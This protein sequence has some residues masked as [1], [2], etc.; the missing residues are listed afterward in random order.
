VSLEGESQLIVPTE[1][2]GLVLKTIGGGDL[3]PYYALVDRNREHLNQR[4]DY[5]FEASATR[6]QLAAWLSSETADVRFGIWLDGNLIGRVYLGPVDPP[7][8]A[9]GYWLGAEST[10]QGIATVACRAAIGHGR[11]LGAS[12]IHAQI[13]KGNEASIAVVRRLE[14][15]HV[16]DVGD[17]TRWRLVLEG[18]PPIAQTNRE[19]L[20]T[21][22]AGPMPALRVA[23]LA[24]APEI[25]ALMKAAT[26]A[27]F[28]AYYDAPQTASSVRFVAQVDPDL[29]ADGTY[30]VFE[31]D[32]EVVAC[33]GW[34][35]RGRV[36][37]GSA[38]AAGD[39]RYLDPRT[40]AAHIRAMF[41]RA[42]WT[43][44]GLGR[45]IIEASED[46]ARD[47]GFQRMD[48]VATLPG[49]PLYQAAGYVATAEVAD[50]VLADGVPLP[51]Q[52]MS[53]PLTDSTERPGDDDA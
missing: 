32:D 6:D 47:M 22:A 26:A 49:V 28:P 43:R 8:W 52:A 42:D 30:F 46:A 4:G 3:D 29:L 2:A 25:A 40:E 50:I 15:E 12:E 34:S 37:M 39:N 1:R 33:G 13:T 53:K 36:Y 10:R 44:R 41:V 20:T 16:A 45:R 11:R 7:K 14:F 31:A 18:S 27:I 9:I 5:P 17:Q 35:R 38:D 51:C 21:S 23:T 24:D 48:L 19:G